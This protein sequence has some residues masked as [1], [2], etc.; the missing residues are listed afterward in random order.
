MAF[1]G[2]ISYWLCFLLCL[3]LRFARCF[4][5]YKTAIVHLSKDHAE[6]I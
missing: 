5:E 1:H 3:L 4:F 2:N 6:H